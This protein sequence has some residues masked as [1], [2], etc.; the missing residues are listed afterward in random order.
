MTTSRSIFYFNETTS[1]LPTQVNQGP[2]NLSSLGKLLRVTTRGSI[3]QEAGSISPTYQPING[4][5]WGLQLGAHGYTPMNVVTGA[6][7]LDW[8]WTGEIDLGNLLPVWA[9]SSDDAQGFDV[10][11]LTQTWAGQW[12]ISASTDFYLSFGDPFSITGGVYN[13]AGTVE[14]LHT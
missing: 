2:W 11:S 5:N 6:D 8:L 9:P 13:F 10:V 12:D 4:L 14:I 7:S 1:S 3:G